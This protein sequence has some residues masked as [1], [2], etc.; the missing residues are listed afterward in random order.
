MGNKCFNQILFRSPVQSYELV[1]QVQSITLYDEGLFLSSPELWSEYL[2][3]ES[4]D[5]KEKIK[6]QKSLLKYHIRSCA[7]CTPYATFAGSYVVDLADNTNLSLNQ[8]VHKYVR[9][10]M[11]FLSVITNYIASI[12]EVKIQLKLMVNNSV[13][14]LADAYRYAEYALFNNDRRYHITAIDSTEILDGIYAMAQQ[15]IGYKDLLDFI[16]SKAAVNATEAEDFL[17]QLISSQFL[18]SNLEPSVTGVEPLYELVDTLRSMNGIEEVIRPLEEIID[19]VKHPKDG[20]D[21]YKD[22]ETRL[23]SLNESIVVPKNT[24]QVDLIHKPIQTSLEREVVAEL[25]NQVED[26]SCLN[27][28]MSKPDIDTFKTEFYKKYEDSEIP[29]NIAID[30]DLGIGYAG[31]SGGSVGDNAAIDDLMI[32]G[33]RTGG[34]GGQ[35]MNIDYIVHLSQK[36]YLTWIEH[37]TGVIELTPEDLKPFEQ[38]KKASKFSESAA[39]FGSLH[40][41]E[42]LLDKE[43][44]LFE[45]SSNGGPSGANLLGRF[46]L[47]D[48]KVEALCRDITKREEENYPDFIFAEIAHLP[49]SRIGNILLRPCIRDYEIAYIGKSGLPMEKQININDI[50]V[51]IHQNEVLLRSKKF[52]KRIIPRLSTAH[53]YSHNSLPIY[54]FLCDLQGVGYSYPSIW[55]WGTFGNQKYLPRVIYKNI[56]LHKARWNVDE[57]DIKDL[58]KEKSEWHS[59]TLKLKEKLGWSDQVLYSQGDNNLLIKFDN[60]AMVELLIDYLKKYK[61]ITLIEFLFTAE[62]SV[63]KDEQGKPYTNEI[64][65]PIYSEKKIEKK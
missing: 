51:S 45:L 60:P 47:G 20:I 48:P 58:P 11:N 46:A 7:R 32:G 42:G 36:K 6:L 4:L 3:L 54:K 29:L 34:G 62:N 24:I 35:Q 63:V 13:Y 38:N 21:Y 61:R 39:I 28:A 55:D 31:N 65:I 15:W 49:Q 9:I 43:H 37:K 30:A 33:G 50:L 12:P 40:Q 25:V 14:K 2:K 23:K 8:Q 52:N 64:L 27:R 56:I 41:T 1:D 19:I 53:N 59:Y 18:I 44:F 16:Q 17:H 26:L 10:D 22:I 5:E 57:A